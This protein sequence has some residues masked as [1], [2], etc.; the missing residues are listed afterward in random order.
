MVCLRKVIIF[1]QFV[2]VRVWRKGNLW[3]FDISCYFLEWEP[4]FC[5]YKDMRDEQKHM[6]NNLV[7]EE[8]VLES[9]T[10]TYPLQTCVSM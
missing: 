7:S 3:G 2:V 8:T 6:S 5:H 9:S 4:Q 10:G 1:Q